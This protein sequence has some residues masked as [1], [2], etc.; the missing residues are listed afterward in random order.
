MWFLKKPSQEQIRI[1][2]A[3]QSQQGFSY[4]EVGASRAETPAGYDLDHN[5]IPLGK[6]RPVYEA[7]CAAVKRWQM[8]SSPWT[9]IYPAETPLQPGNVVAMLAHA[10]RLWWLNACRI[11]YVIDEMNT[12]CR[13]GFAYGTLPGHVE[14]GEERFSIEWDADDTVWY[15]IRAFS[16]PRYWLVRWTYPLA[17]RMQRRFVLDSQAAMR[18]AVAH[19]SHL[20]GSESGL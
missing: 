15:D 13:F 2:L 18:R 3:C 19:L 17:R 1:F 11:V 6:G 8:F 9:Q 12:G 10:F 7:A 5:R 14:S 4:G 16:R 20:A